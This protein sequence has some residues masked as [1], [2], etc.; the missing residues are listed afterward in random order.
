M[1]RAVVYTMPVRRCE[2]G[3]EVERVEGKLVHA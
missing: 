1:S 3:R 2:R